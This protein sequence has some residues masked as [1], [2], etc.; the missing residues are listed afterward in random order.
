MRC[1]RNS[2]LVLKHKIVDVDCLLGWDIMVS[3]AFLRTVLAFE[4]LNHCVLSFLFLLS[5]NYLLDVLKSL[6]TTLKEVLIGIARSGRH[7]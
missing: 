6:K 4:C 5:L 3:S 7:S 2:T 1:P